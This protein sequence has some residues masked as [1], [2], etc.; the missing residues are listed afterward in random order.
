M[1]T[2]YFGNKKING[3]SVSIARFPP[4]GWRGERCIKLAPSI[5]LFKSAKEGKITWKDFCKRYQSEVLEKLNPK[6]IYVELKDKVLCCWEKDSESCHRRLVAQ[7]IEKALGVT[8]QE[9]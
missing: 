7:W 2:S 3:N 9:L 1:K 6:E 5:D 8:I 4:R